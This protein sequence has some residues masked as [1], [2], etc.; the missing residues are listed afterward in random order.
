[1]NDEI[2]AVRHLENGVSGTEAKVRCVPP[3]GWV[4][5]QEYFVPDTA[6]G[7]AYVDNG[8]RRLLYDSQINLE[9]TGFANY[10]RTVQS[11]NSRAG[12][13][14]AAHFAVEFDPTYQRIE[15]HAIRVV[16]GDGQIDHAKAASFQLLRR[17]TRLEKLALD[18]RLTASLLISDLR[19]DDVLD[20]AITIRSHHPILGGN[21]A[22]WIAFNSTAPW[23]ETRH[24]LLRRSERALFQKPFNRPPEGVVCSAHGACEMSWSLAAQERIQVED[25]SPPWQILAPAIQLT[26]F[27]SWGQ[28][29]LLFCPYYIDS[30]LPSD[31]AAEVDRLEHEF[32]DVADRVAEWLRFV[33]RQLRYFAQ[34]LGEGGIVPRSIDV[35]WMSRFGDCKDAARLFVAGARRMGADACAALVSTTHGLAI[36]EL[37]PSPAVFNHCI[38]RVRLNNKTHWLDPTMSRQEGRLDV[39]YQ[40]HAGWALPLTPDS[41]LERLPD[42]EP[43]HYRHTEG[44]LKIG[45]KVGDPAALTFRVDLYSFAADALRHRIENEGHSKYSEQVLTELRTTWPDLVE[46]APLSFMDERAD[47][48]L[49][50]VFSYEIRNAWKSVDKKRRLGFRIAANSIAAELN[51]LKQ[52]QRRTDV[53]LGHPRQS[54]WRVRIHMPRAWHGGGWNEVLNPTN[55]RFSNE[56]VIAERTLILTKEILISEWTLPATE[57]SAYQELVTKLRTN[58]TTVFASPLL[59]R[60]FPATGGPLGLIRRQWFRLWWVVLWVGYLVY[61]ALKPSSNP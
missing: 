17:E 59:G 15:V 48:R 18:G 32:P 58:V 5:Y 47:N 49:T 53:F 25:L 34:T 55:L 30:E 21:Y 1:M 44:E 6:V 41:T 42:N 16:R 37:L 33:Q 24:R 23:H 29:A 7:D 61:V 10:L 28:I 12:A 45:S 26:E 14:K 8:V 20:V 52:T 54:T 39:I 56:L 22:G 31:L 40:P 19:I 51:P 36:G 57:A 46:T 11:I 38:V 4:K 60:I 9:S 27:R 2:S 43:V 50:A 13:E 3:P 35:I